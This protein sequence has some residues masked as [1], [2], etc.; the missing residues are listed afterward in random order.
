M[1][2]CPGSSAPALARP[3]TPSLNIS[4]QTASPRL[5]VQPGQDGVRDRADA[6]LQRRAVADERGNPVADDGGR[7]VAGRSGGEGSGASASI[8]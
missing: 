7:L 5:A 3:S 1:T 6:S 4:D 2:G 8:A